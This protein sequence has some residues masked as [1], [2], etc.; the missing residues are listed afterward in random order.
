MEK[1]LEDIHSL[2]KADI[3]EQ[4]PNEA[5]RENWPSTQHFR[6][7]V[8][9]ATRLYGVAAEPML[10]KIL[11][12]ELRLLAQI[13]MAQALLGRPRTSGSISVSRSRR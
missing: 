10:G 3:D 4:A 2:Y 5:L 13:E 9:M 7:V 12:H 8:S 1:A 11:D 6:R